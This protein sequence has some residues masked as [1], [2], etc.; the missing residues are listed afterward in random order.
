ME[1]VLNQTKWQTKLFMKIYSW[2]F[3]FNLPNK[4]YIANTL[5]I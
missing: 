3:L 1:K 2:L 4:I 5:S